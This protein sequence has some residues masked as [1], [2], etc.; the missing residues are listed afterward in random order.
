MIRIGREIQCLPY[1]GFFNVRSAEKKLQFRPDKC[2]TLKIAHTNSTCTQSEELF[3]D[4]W[5]E[6]HNKEGHL[7]ESFE[8]KV[9]M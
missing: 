2:H 6:K 1:A 5:S 4:H 8:E 7:I 9:K 3:I